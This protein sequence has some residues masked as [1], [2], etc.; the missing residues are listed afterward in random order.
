MEKKSIAAEDEHPSHMG[1]KPAIS[2]LEKA[3]IKPEEIDLI[4][5]CGV[6][7]Y[8][9]RFWSPAAKIKGISAGKSSHTFEVENFCNSGNL[10]IHICRNMLQTDSA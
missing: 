1:I 3:E 8:D 5:Y 7:D 10:G 4:V 2:A 9:Y 6:G